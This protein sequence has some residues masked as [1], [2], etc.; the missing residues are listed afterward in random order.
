AMFAE[1]EA[2]D[3]L[4]RA[5]EGPGAAVGRIDRSETGDRRIESDI[6][7]A[8][9]AP[10]VFEEQGLAAGAG[11]GLHAEDY[12]SPQAHRV[13]L[14]RRVLPALEGRDIRGFHGRATSGERVEAHQLETALVAPDARALARHH[15]LRSTRRPARPL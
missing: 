10:Q 13:L 6:G 11:E 12:R 8:P 5:A 15:H 14:P 7:S 1:P 2:L 3:V 4:G 9:D